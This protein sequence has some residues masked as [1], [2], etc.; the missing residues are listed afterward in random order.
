MSKQKS[1]AA[2]RHPG[3]RPEK[4]DP[5]RGS[6][7]QSSS[8]FSPAA[9]REIVESVVIAFVLAFLFRTFEAEAFVIPTGSMA[10]TLM[11]RHKDLECEACGYSYR[12][13]ASA[14][15]DKESSRPTGVQITS[16]TCPVCRYTMNVG[17]NNPRGENYRSYK[18]DRILVG[19]FPYQFA[20]PERWD[21]AVF[22]Y[23]G[24]ARTN[25]IK[26]V[27]GLPG[28]TLRIRHGDIFTERDGQPE[29]IAR[30]PL[31]KIRAM[32]QP[33][34]DNDY[35]LPQV[36]EGHWPARWTPRAAGPS[37]PGDWVA[38]EDL[39]SFRVAGSADQEVWLS[40]QHRVPSYA[41]WEKWLAGQWSSQDEIKPQLITD[42]NAY[43]TSDPSSG[44][45]WPGS[46]WPS[47][48][49]E[50]AESGSLRPGQPP[51]GETLGLNWVGDLALECE[52]EVEE[53]TGTVTF[54]LI[55]G[56]KRLGCVIDLATGKGSFRIDGEEQSTFSTPMSAAGEYKVL[57]ANIDDQLTLDI[58]GQT[59]V[60]AY[61][62][63]GNHR[64]TA[65]DLEPVR[66]ASQGAKLSV[67]HLKVGRDIYY[68]ALRAG[69]G[70][71]P[72][73]TEYDA[74]NNPFRTQSREEVARVLSSPE[75]WGG[76][77]RGNEVEFK[78][79]PDQF[80]MLGD[81]SAASQDSRWWEALN[82]EYYVSRELL[83]GKALVIYWPHS[84]DEI[85]GTPIPI[86]FFPNFWRMGLVR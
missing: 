85:P 65:D 17:R 84:L 23:P 70:R 26:R 30:K 18:G 33:V 13:S 63:Q 25:Y 71:E 12:V 1:V 51:P 42:F 60:F 28:E 56:G 20:D 61:E 41:D 50:G 46:F 2:P 49:A 79:G 31:D 19:K 53:A 62:P 75:E 57:L 38:S 27:V 37:Q 22:K 82:A 11:G 83:I 68:I 45:G 8:T 86:R 21:V 35:V 81:N 32:L 73:V 64:P 24:E 80:F 59:T 67:R 15:V 5:T 39:K 54:E 72:R 4:G 34:H 74:S 58:D 55:E 77:A 52:V 47:N 40:Y 10:P 14:E 9:M 16:A 3:K 44:G 48:M 66:I 43:N 7:N 36:A 76:F 69:D 78:L 6:A 29:T